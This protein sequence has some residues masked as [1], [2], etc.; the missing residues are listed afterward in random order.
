[1]HFTVHARERMRD[2]G[3]S[4]AEVVRTVQ[5]PAITYPDGA[6]KTNLIRDDLRVVAASDGKLVI[7]VVWL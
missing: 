5:D 4:E 1:M 6:G 3:V 7:T 2:H